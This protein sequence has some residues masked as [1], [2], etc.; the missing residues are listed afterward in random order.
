MT[1]P[2]GTGAVEAMRSA[3][4]DS[5]LNADT[6]MLIS[7]HGTGTFANDYAEAAALHE[8]FGHALE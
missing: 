7:S 5:Q 6:P 8:V 1:H 4:A 3:L 2:N